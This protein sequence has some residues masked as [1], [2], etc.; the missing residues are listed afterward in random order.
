MV[1]FALTAENTVVKESGA[2]GLKESYCRRATN[3]AIA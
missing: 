2:K 1:V 3:E